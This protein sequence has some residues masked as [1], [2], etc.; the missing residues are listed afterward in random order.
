DPGPPFLDD[1]GWEQAGTGR[2][3]D[4]ALEVIGRSQAVADECACDAAVIE[5][6][7]RIGDQHEGVVACGQYVGGVLADRAVQAHQVAQFGV[8]GVTAGD[9]ASRQV[10]GG[11]GGVGVLVVHPGLCR[12]ELGPHDRAVDGQIGAHPQLPQRIGVDGAQVEVVRHDVAGAVPP[13][14]QSV[15][16]DGDVG[17]GVR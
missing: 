1:V 13:V 8:V 11:G 3:L 6:V 10:V 12:G 9:P 4:E 17:P 7:G 14:G 15:V 5:V 2:L 16:P